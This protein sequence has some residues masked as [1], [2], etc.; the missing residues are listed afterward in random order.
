VRLLTRDVT[1]CCIHLAH[2][3]GCWVAHTG[4]CVQSL[5]PAAGCIYTYKLRSLCLCGAPQHS[6]PAR[7]LQVLAPTPTD[8]THGLGRLGLATLLLCIVLRIVGLL[9]LET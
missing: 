5:C 2:H 4:E 6:P 9:A 7:R 1:L 8:P 3:Y